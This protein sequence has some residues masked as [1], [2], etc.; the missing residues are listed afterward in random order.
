M[1]SSTLI[2]LQRRVREAIATTS[3]LTADQRLAVLI[4]VERAWTEA[5]I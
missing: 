5:G 3:E 4:A 2:D 1:P